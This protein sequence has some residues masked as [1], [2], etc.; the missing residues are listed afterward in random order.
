MLHHAA[1]LAFAVAAGRSTPA[2]LDWPRERLDEPHEVRCRKALPDDTRTL[3]G[4]RVDQETLDRFEALLGSSPLHSEGDASTG[5][6]WRCWEGANGDGT[7]LVL[8]RGEVD[9]QFQ[10][11]GREM[12]SVARG[13][14][15]KSKLVSRALVTGN[16]VR[17]GLTR[18]DVERKVGRATTAGAGWFDRACLSKQPMTE[19]E[20]VALHAGARGA[21]EVFSRIT[22]VEA[23][24]RVE[25]F[26]VVW[27]VTD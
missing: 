4:V 14:C 26:R 16:G 15:P 19:K 6:L 21:W 1:L 7:V 11:L 10:V 9:A 27:G 12:K 24:G 25:G 23:H 8:G 3:L 20:R 17:L 13:T 2:E 5:F 22:V 18:A